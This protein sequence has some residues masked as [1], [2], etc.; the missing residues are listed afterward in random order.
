MEI[1]N[2]I[3]ETENPLFKRKEIELEVQAEVTP[4]YVDVKKMLVKKFS[5]KLDTIRIKKIHGSFGSKT[6]LI[7]ANIYNTKEDRDST[8]HFSKKEKEAM[9]KAEEPAPESE[10]PL[11][12]KPKE[13]FKEEKNAADAEIDKIKVNKESESNDDKIID[14]SSNQSSEHKEEKNE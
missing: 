6:F 13:E 14:N 2:I 8:E 12:E 5:V 3:K 9:K 4:S 7:T 1:A 10:K 11:E